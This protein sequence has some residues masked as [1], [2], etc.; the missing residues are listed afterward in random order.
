MCRSVDVILFV[1]FLD[2]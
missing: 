2:R 1:G